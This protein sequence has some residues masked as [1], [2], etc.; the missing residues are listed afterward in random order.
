MR[1]VSSEMNSHSG[2][3]ELAELHVGGHVLQAQRP[4]DALLNVEHARHDVI[5]RFT[6]VGDGQQIVQ[7]HAMHARPAQVVGNPFGLHA[8]GQRH[9]TIEIIFVERRGGGD[10]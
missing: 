2:I 4:A 5:E 6:R 1:R 7:V 3:S 9:E 10:R 8:F